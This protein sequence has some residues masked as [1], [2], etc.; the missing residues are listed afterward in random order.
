LIEADGGKAKVSNPRSTI[1][2]EGFLPC[3]VSVFQ[4]IDFAKPK[5]GR[6]G[7]SYSIRFLP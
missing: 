3:V 7:V 2:G 4:A 5:N 1:E 6:T